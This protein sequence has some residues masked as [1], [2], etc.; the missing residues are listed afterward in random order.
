MGGQTTK[1]RPEKPAT[2]YEDDLYTWVEE[3]CALLR[4]GRL[5]EVDALNVAEEL[6]DLAK[7]QYDKLESA[8]A[9]LI[10]HLL[11]WDH[12]PSRRS[13]SWQ[14]TMREQRRRILRV[15]KDSPGL[16]S[17]LGE[18]M[19]DGYADGRDRA[20]GETKL[21]ESVFPEACPYTFDDMMARVIEIE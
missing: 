16:K 1:T 17:R 6:S 2:R 20:L 11:K 12:Q 18:A 9:V 14:M 21:K 15:L 3:Q 8:F 4:A 7:A 10:Q 13:R 5:S 19:A